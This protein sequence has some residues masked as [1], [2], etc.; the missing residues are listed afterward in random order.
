MGEETGEETAEDDDVARR[1]QTEVDEV[2]VE[3]GGVDEGE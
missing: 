3:V 2:V 1:Q